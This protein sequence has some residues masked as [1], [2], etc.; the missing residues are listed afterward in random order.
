MAVPHHRVCGAQWPPPPPPFDPLN[1]KG[2]Q[3]D[4]TP[5]MPRGRYEEGAFGVPALVYGSLGM[6]LLLVVRPLSV[7]PA[8]T[9]TRR[10][11][12]TQRDR[13]NVLCPLC[14]DQAPVPRIPLYG[15]LCDPCAFCT[16]MARR[17][18]HDYFRE[19]SSRCRRSSAAFI[20][21]VTVCTAPLRRTSPGLAPAG[22]LT[23]LQRVSV[24]FT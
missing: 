20:S 11:H 10:A 23:C 3:R 8:C 1:P 15:P 24:T 13:K 17:I 19:A 5:L 9:G 6:S 16:T 12:R 2:M 14:P 7:S 18:P 21:T 4:G 22:L